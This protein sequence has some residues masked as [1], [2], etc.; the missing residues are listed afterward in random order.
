MN[1]GMANNATIRLEVAFSD[2]EL[3]AIEAWR[4]ANDFDS[5]AIATR[6]LVRLGLLSEI[7]RVYRTIAPQDD[8]D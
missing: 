5:Q 6:Q 3:A 7:G 2:D 1:D 4:Q 8:Q